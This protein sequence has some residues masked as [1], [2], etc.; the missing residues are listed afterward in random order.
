MYYYTSRD[1]KH[2]EN[3]KGFNKISKYDDTDYHFLKEILKISR[4]IE[5]HNES[6]N[7]SIYNEIILYIRKI[8]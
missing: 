3:T 1:K 2:P 6:L 8:P 5:F 4:N 7:V